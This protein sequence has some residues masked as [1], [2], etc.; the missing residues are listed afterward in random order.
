MPL[1]M[2]EMDETSKKGGGSLSSLGSVAGGVLAGVATAAVAA[3][4]MSIKMAD[5]F[6]ASHS[7]LV[8][9]VTAAGQSFPALQGAVKQTDQSMENL[10]FTNATTE[11]A[12]A[13]MTVALQ[14]PTK[15]MSLMSLA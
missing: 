1:A 13:S 9:A 12:L 15:A 6:E 7:Q 4:A 14:N 3:G 8:T 10:G 5:D 2:C 11:G